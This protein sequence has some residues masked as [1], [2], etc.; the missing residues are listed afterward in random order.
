MEHINIF[1]YEVFYL[2]Y[3]EGNLGEEET[4]L[5]LDFLRKHP[6]LELLDE[7]LPMLTDFDIHLSKEEK[8]AL[9][10][11]EETDAITT[12]NAQYFLIADAEEILSPEK[13][14]ELNAIVAESPVLQREQ[15][16]FKSVYLKP[17]LAIQ[18]ADKA[19]LKQDRKIAFWPYIAGIAAAG[20]VAFFVMF[21]NDGSKK[22]IEIAEKDAPK[23]EVEHKHNHPAP[24][25]SLN[26]KNNGTQVANRSVN[27]GVKNDAPSG[28]ELVQVAQET[29]SQRKNTFKVDNLKQRQ[30]R[31]LVQEV[32]RTLARV[33]PK[34]V[35]PVAPVIKENPSDQA[36]F[37]I[38]DMKN[39]IEPLTDQ[40]KKRI[41]TDVDFRHA[42]PTK[43]KQGGFY[44]KI[45]KLEIIRKTE[46]KS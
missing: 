12:E 9:K 34:I 24:I 35:S 19:A 18:Y 23:T 32:D 6:E 11:T 17:N 46:K 25:E 14:N 33:T 26:E 27:V 4:R 28:N 29:A 20:I 45:G 38:N 43:N 8:N 1:N 36:L 30:A 37:G 7:E 21:P 10:Q 31:Q 3:L 13:K 40:L 15:A 39:P 2:D 22:G 41:S 42:K 16:L 44:L 5:L